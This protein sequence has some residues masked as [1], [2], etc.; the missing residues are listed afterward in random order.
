MNKTHCE[1][2]VEFFAANNYQVTLGK[3]LEAGYGSYAHS[4]NKR[5]SDL[6]DKGYSITCEKGLIP[7]ENI[8]RMK[9]PNHIPNVKKMDAPHDFETK[10]EPYLDKKGFADFP[11]GQL[12]F[13]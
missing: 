4:L 8:Y 7:T 12:K 1:M 9:L 11:E 5:I 13:F 2:I 3:L 10:T 6:R